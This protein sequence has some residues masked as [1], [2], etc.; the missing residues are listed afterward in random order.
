MKEGGNMV[1][2]KEYD[3]IIKECKDLAIEKNLLYGDDSFK[4]FNGSAI[5]LRII[6][7]SSRL[8]NVFEQ[9]FKDGDFAYQGYNENIEDTLKDLINYSIYLLMSERKL[10]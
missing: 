5:V 9:R 8:R 3:K 1:E 7:K 6:D 10:L 2:F 4:I